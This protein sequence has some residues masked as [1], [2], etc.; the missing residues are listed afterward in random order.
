ME[1]I[2]EKLKYRKTANRS[3]WLLLEHLT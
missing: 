1:M 3:P 2:R